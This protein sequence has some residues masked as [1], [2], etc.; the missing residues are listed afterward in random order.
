M[1]KQEYS[2]S[3]II[4]ALVLLVLIAGLDFNPTWSVIIALAVFL[5]CLITIKIMKNKNGNI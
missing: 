2:I 3:G 5:I 4:T 1:E